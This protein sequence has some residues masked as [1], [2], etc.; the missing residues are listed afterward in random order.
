MKVVFVNKDIGY[1]TCLNDITL[2][3]TYEVIKVEKFYS[4]DLKDI[5]K[6]YKIK[7]DKGYY[8][9]R[10]SKLFIEQKEYRN[11]RIN[12]ILNEM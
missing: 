5:I 12:E 3:K 10:N 1:D 9:E 4:I 7:T 11:K 8:S 6:L 2:Y